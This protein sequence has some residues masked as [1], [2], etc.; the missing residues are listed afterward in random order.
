MHR[1]ILIPVVSAMAIVM[2]V[3]LPSAEATAAAPPTASAANKVAICHVKKGEFVGMRLVVQS[4]VASHL[5][6]GD[7]LPLE[8]FE[9]KDLDGDGAGELVVTCDETGFSSNNCDPDDENS[10]VMCPP[11][12]RDPLQFR[13]IKQ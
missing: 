8:L 9:D 3:M 4:S 13:S 7:Y 6:H 10:S 2:S 11:D 12:P 5:S 1:E